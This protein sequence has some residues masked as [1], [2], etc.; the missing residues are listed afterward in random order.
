MAPFQ[1]HFLPMIPV[2]PPSPIDAISLEAPLKYSG[3]PQGMTWARGQDEIGIIKLD[4][5]SLTS[6][7]KTTAHTSELY[8]QL[9]QL[10]PRPANYST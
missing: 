7:G 5:A 1:P 3:D 4:L 6:P 9:A 2:V 10:G 8:F